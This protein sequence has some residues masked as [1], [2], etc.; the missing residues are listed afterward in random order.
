MGFDSDEPW[1]ALRAGTEVDDQAAVGTD[2]G[3]LQICHGG[4]TKSLFRSYTLNLD[5]VIIYGRWMAVLLWILMSAVIFISDTHIY[6]G[7]ESF[8]GLAAGTPSSSAYLEMAGYSV[9]SY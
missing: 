6:I 8:A 5:E 4:D 1:L 7:D 9:K 3:N 2:A